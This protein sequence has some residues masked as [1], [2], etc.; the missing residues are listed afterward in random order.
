MAYNRFGRSR[1]NRNDRT[2]YRRYLP[3]D[4]QMSFGPYNQ[5][6]R[7]YRDNDRQVNDYG[8]VDP[9]QDDEDYVS[10]S[11]RVGAAWQDY[12]YRPTRSYG[13]FRRDN[14][15]RFGRT[16]DYHYEGQPYGGY[17]PSYNRYESSFDQNFQRYSGTGGY[18]QVTDYRGR[19]P[20]GWKR[21]DERI[22][23]DVSDLLERHPY[24]DASEIEVNVKD[25]VVILSGSVEDRR[26]KRMTE[27]AVENLPGVKDVRNELNVDQSLFQQI[28]E[29]F[30]GESESSARH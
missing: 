4:R 13:S 19:G 10:A 28:K 23:E 18:G 16:R 26:T 11:H 1:A 24:I 9:P 6:E 25:G 12:D 29:A 5:S 8:P 22:K 7:D 27:D 20:K 30:T 15:N 3:D 21:S 2:G 17:E 14:N